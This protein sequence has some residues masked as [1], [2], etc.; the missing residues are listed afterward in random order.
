[1]ATRLKITTLAVKMSIEQAVEQ[2]KTTATAIYN[3]ALEIMKGSIK[4]EQIF[5][6]RVSPFANLRFLI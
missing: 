6:D 1:M 3:Q 4:C 2:G 5:G